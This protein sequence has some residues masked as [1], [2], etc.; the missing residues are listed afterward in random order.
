[1]PVNNFYK[2]VT[3]FVFNII[4]SYTQTGECR[5]STFSGDYNWTCTLKTPFLAAVDSDDIDLVKHLWQYHPTVQQV[6][7]MDQ[8]KISSMLILNG[9]YSDPMLSKFCN[10]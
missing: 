5:T 8:V 2:I 10:I 4:I 1:M 6:K 9:Y 3:I 7:V